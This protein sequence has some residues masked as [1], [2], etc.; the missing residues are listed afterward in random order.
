MGFTYF[1]HQV[2][3]NFREAT[4]VNCLEFCRKKEERDVVLLDGGMVVRTAPTGGMVFP[5]PV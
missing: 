4:L 3:S 2:K 5:L 1:L